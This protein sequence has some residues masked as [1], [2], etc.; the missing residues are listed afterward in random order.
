M[1]ER[2]CPASCPAPRRGGPDSVDGLLGVEHLEDRELVV[3]LRVRLVLVGRWSWPG[4]TRRRRIETAP[5]ERVQTACAARRPGVPADGRPRRSPTRRSAPRRARTAPRRRRTGS[6]C[7]RGRT[8]P[9][10]PAGRGSAPPRTPTAGSR[11]PRHAAV[12]GACCGD[13]RGDRRVGQRPA[14]APSSTSAT[15]STGQLVAAPVERQP[16]GDQHQPRR[17]TAGRRP[18]RA[19]EP[20]VHAA[21]HHHQ[22]QRRCTRNTTDVPASVEAEPALAEQRER[23]LERGERRTTVMNPTTARRR[24][25]GACGHADAGRTC[26]STVAA[27]LGQPDDRGDRVDRRQHAGDVERDVRPAE[28]G[29]PA[30]R[31]AEHE[32]DAERRA[33]Q[34]EQPRAL[35]RR[36]DVGDRRLGD[37][38]AAAGRAVD[39]PPDEQQP[40]RA[41]GAGD[42]AA[43]RGADQRR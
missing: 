36:G 13:E 11:A 16:G 37:R 21:L 20:A 40:Q 17:G 30:D 31:R 33:E 43:D 1:P 15:I 14:R 2:R 28:R 9:R 4:G 25:I 38:Q 27:G 39:D 23:R 29:Q 34:A 24:R 26:R 10:P 22:H 19:D 42:E 18:M 7:R 35:L 12:G 5:L 8:S 32:A 41:G 6:R 3:S